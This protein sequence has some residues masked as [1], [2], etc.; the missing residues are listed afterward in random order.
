MM[1]ESTRKTAVEYLVDCLRDGMADRAERYMR[2]INASGAV[3]VLRM[4]DG[5]VD[6]LP[7]MPADVTEPGL[8]VGGPA[9][10]EAFGPTSDE[11][12]DQIAFRLFMPFFLLPREEATSWLSIDERSI[13]GNDAL[14]VAHCENCARAIGPLPT[15]AALGYV[16]GT[17]PNGYPVV[18]LLGAGVMH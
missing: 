15:G 16:S 2:R 18:A 14:V 5:G 12:L 4:A 17:S 10:G 13:A 9:L 3:L 8:W 1:D 7:E 6:R 11:R